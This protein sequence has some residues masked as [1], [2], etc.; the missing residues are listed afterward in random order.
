MLLFSVERVSRPHHFLPGTQN[1]HLP[2]ADVERRALQTAIGL[3]DDD[4]VDAS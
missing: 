3:A 4:D 2:E 1:T